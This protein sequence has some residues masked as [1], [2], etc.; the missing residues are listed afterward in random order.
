MVPAGE[1]ALWW[2]ESYLQRIRPRHACR[3]TADCPALFLSARGGFLGR[4]KLTERMHHYLETSGIGKPGA[5]HIWR[6]SA[7]TLMLEG[8]ADIRF[9]QEL[10]GHA[11][12]ETTQIYTRVSIHRLKEVHARTH[13]AHVTRAPSSSAAEEGVD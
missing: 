7:A 13:P 1:R 9:V 2:T 10:L 11:K 12:L 3:G 6:H 8:G 5:C 4:A